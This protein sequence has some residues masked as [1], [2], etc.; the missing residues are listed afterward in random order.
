MQKVIENVHKIWL[1]ETTGCDI[2]FERI[3]IW[4]MNK[5]NDGGKKDEF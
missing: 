4:K 5:L 1:N 2:G 3:I